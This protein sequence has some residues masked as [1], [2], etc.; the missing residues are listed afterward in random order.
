MVFRYDSHIIIEDLVKLESNV[1]II[2][3]SMERYS[4]IFTEKF[5]FIDSKNH[6][7]G[8]LDKLSEM[9]E[10]SCGELLNDYVEK[11]Y[12]STNIG[13]LIRY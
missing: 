9:V 10:D 3:K 7:K 1:R 4:C 11:F 5:R 8:S 6:R 2:P 12:P 13:N